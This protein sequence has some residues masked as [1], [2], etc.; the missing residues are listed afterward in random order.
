MLLTCF[1]A[2]LS[3]FNILMVKIENNTEIWK[4]EKI[5]ILTPCYNYYSLNILM[6]QS[7]NTWNHSS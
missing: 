1:L 3:K 6:F 5:F 4:M 2:F 7:V